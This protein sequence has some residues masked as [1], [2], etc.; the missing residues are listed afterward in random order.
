M[1]EHAP[2]ARLHR[3]STRRRFAA[4]PR[5]ARRSG[6]AACRRRPSAA[7][8]SNVLA[9]LATAPGPA[10]RAGARRRCR[11]RWRSRSSRARVR[12]RANAPRR[13]RHA[14]REPLR[15]SGVGEVPVQRAGAVVPHRLSDWAR[16]AVKNVPGADPA[17]E[18][19]VGFT[20]R[21]GLELVAPDNYLPTNPQLIGQTVD[22]NGRN[23]V[24]GVQAPRRGR[25]RARCK[26]LGPVGVENYE[27]GKQRRGRRRARWC[28]ATS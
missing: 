10:G 14:L 15:R 25:R 18:N 4:L 19:I 11:S 3:S 24:R 1:T 17:A 9:R 7:P 27:V 22:E 5:D 8:G 6:P 13:G 21:E 12:C 23:L 20:V 2:Q 16:E 26:G 28:C